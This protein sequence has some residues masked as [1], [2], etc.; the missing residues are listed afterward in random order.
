M[1]EALRVFI[2]YAHEDDLLCQELEK[3]L[4]VLKHQGLM[5]VWHDREIYAGKEWMREIEDN[6]N[7]AHILLLVS[8]A[9]INSQYCYSIEM[10]SAL[11]RHQY[12]EACVIPIILRP[13][14]W[15]ETPLRELQALPTDAKPVTDS[16]W[17]TKDHAFLD[18]IEVER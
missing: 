1:P 12:E 6:L 5:S 2:S 15:R 10:E 18:I 13:S 9:F 4:S 3:Q 17:H 7:E 14:A 16:F 11:E 8:P